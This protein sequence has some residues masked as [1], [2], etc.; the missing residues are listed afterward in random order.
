MTLQ[1]TAGIAALILTTA[2]TGCGRD[3]TVPKAP[4]TSPT[5][6][7]APSPTTAPAPAPRA[8]PAGTAPGEPS[9]T[10]GQTVDDATITSKVKA[11]LLQADEVKGTDIN[12]DTMGGTVTLKGA[13]ESQPQIDRAVTIAKGIEGVRD[14]KNTLMVRAK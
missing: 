1:H 3:E 10:V 4:P 7:T 2:V 6:Q 13:V 8:G 12:V 5:P 11:A 14:V 9:R